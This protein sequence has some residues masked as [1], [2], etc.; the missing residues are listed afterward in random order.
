MKNKTVPDDKKDIYYF[1]VE[2]LGTGVGNAWLNEKVTSKEVIRN[3][4]LQVAEEIM[5]KLKPYLEKEE[6]DTADKVLAQYKNDQN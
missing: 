6:W 5:E 4:K 1:L 3:I 2:E